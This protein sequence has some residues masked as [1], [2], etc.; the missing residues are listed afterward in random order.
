M[1]NRYHSIPATPDEITA[2]NIICRMLAGMGFRFYWATEELTEEIYAFQPCDGAWSIGET[3]EHIWDILN[4]IYRAIDPAGKAKPGGIKQLREGALELIAILEETFS[5][6]DNE[7]LA[8]IQLLK[9]PFWLII[10][11][12]LSDALTHIGQ[13]ATLRRIVGSP[14]PDSNP[15]EGKQPPGK[16]ESFDQSSSQVIGALVLLCFLTSYWYE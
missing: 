13:I 16:W 4:W 11:G 7:E 3:V 10:N 1:E 8:A 15:F 6:M 5:K 14:V 12:P 9:Q 2:V